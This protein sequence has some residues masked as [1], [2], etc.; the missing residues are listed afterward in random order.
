MTDSANPVPVA[1]APPS[2]DWVDTMLAEPSVETPEAPKE[3]PQAPQLEKKGAEPKPKTVDEL[4]PDEIF[5]LAK[6]VKH[7]AKVDGTEMDV[8]Y[9]ELV[10]SYQLQKHLINRTKDVEGL[11]KKING[12]INQDI[13][14]D[15]IEAL[16]NAGADPDKLQEAIEKAVY[17]RLQREAMTPEQ[18]EAIEAKEE[19][20]RMKAEKEQSE[21]QSKQAQYEA[22]VKQYQEKFETE[23]VGALREQGI[24]SREVAQMAAYEMLRA[25]QAGV[26]LSGRDAVREAVKEWR[27]SLKSSISSLDEERLAEELGPEGI[28]KVRNYLLKKAK[29]QMPAMT[30]ATPVNPQPKANDK[31][32][33][34]KQKREELRKRAEAIVRGEWANF[35]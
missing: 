11:A 23:I 32:L 1:E 19:L 10:R 33:T 6:K 35:Q 18:R 3:E 30:P 28:E 15:P 8:D 2:G 13:Y 22:Q 21:A 25:Q 5:E 12:L 14:N 31:P 27:N 34:E 26:E 4:T 7:R 20:A 9:D 16:K 29:K 17:K 24:Q